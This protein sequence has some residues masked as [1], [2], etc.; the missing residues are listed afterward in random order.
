[1]TI[2]HPAI[3]SAVYALVQTVEFDIQLGDQSWTTRIEILQDTA[4]SDHFRARVWESELFR[5]TPTFPQ[6]PPGYPAEQADDI[7]QVDRG[8]GHNY[9]DYRDFVAPSADAALRR[10]IA[11]FEQ[12]LARVSGEEH[13][14][15]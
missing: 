6:D 8:I 5:L 1:M 11:D 2:R 9:Q 3:T 15:F 12:F 14:S 10:V 13:L 7:L 4:R